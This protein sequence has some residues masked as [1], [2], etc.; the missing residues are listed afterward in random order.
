MELH[1]PARILPKE[2][3]GKGVRKYIIVLSLTTFR[4]YIWK[5][6]I[7]E[8]QNSNSKCERFVE[9]MEGTTHF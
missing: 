5:E 3:A 7:F 8:H 1:N 9:L 4:C 6:D 2:E